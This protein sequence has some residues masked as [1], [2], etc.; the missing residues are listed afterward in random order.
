MTE[1]LQNTQQLQPGVTLGAGL[2]LVLGRQQQVRPSGSSN[3][4]PPTMS[5][6]SVQGQQSGRLQEA[7][8]PSLHAMD[9]PG[10][11]S[12]CFVAE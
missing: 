7:G 10:Q 3:K 2:V 6:S 1:S 12:L 11:R 9:R 4:H 5:S 8:P